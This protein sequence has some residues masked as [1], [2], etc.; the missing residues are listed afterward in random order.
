L[1][2]IT[3]KR[4]IKITT[5]HSVPPEKKKKKKRASSPLR[6]TDLKASDFTLE[7]LLPT[8]KV[9]ECSEKKLMKKMKM[10]HIQPKNIYI[11]EKYEERIREGT[12]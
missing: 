5:K 3:P 6:G 1:Q 10:R 7:N 2:K 8:D 4:I 12:G 11:Y 9:G